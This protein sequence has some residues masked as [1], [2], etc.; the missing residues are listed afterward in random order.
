MAGIGKAGGRA[1]AVQ[2]DVASLAEATRIF[3]RAEEA[4]GG[5]DVLVNNAGMMDIK[6][7][8]ELEEATFDRLM[9]VNVKGTFNMLHLAARRLRDGGRIINLSSSALITSLPGYGAYNASKAAVDAVTRV[10]AKE[11]GPRR[12]TV[13]AVAPGPV[14]TELFFQGKTPELVERLTRLIPLGRLGE[15]EDIAP[16]VTFL[17]SPESGWINGQVIRANGGMG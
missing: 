4:F 7:L 9:G 14:A 8:A 3:E 12:I 1:I 2:A 16:I 11:L 6:P 17:A 15:V 5:V 10:L 13:N